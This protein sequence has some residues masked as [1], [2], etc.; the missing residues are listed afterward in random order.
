MSAA[1]RPSFSLDLA[2]PSRL[3][4]ERLFARLGSGRYPLRRTRS[5]GSEHG[6]AKVRERDH[7]ILTVPDAEQHFWSPWLN[8]EVT[9]QGE[10]SHLFARFS[11]HPSVWTMFAFAYLGLSTVLL[12]SLCV[13]GALV[14]SG[15]SPWALWISAAAALIMVAMW[16][17]SQV[18][19]RLAHA[20]MEELRAELERV[21]SVCMEEQDLP[22]AS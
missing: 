22:R 1:I 4:L 6:A 15:S 21:V 17:A 13:A 18:G 3:V 9:P 11:P 19:Q 16:G 14:M 20:Q 10:G 12:L 7:F 8:V 5:F 2:C